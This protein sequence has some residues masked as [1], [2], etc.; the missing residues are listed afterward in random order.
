[1]FEVRTLT[2]G[3]QSAPSVLAW[4]EELIGGAQRTLDFAHYDLNLGPENASLVRDGDP[5][6]VRA[7]RRGSLP[8]QH[9]PPEPD[10]GSAASGARRRADR[11]VRRSRRAIA[12]V[13]D[14]MHHKYVVR[15]GETVW[16]GSMNWTD[17]SFTRQENVVAIVRS[18]RSQRGSRRTSPSCGRP[19]PSS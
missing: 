18:R 10:P 14:L 4:I 7:R 9:R 6:G 19:A 3:G 17:D 1:M 15:D 12:G 13:P 11:V 5:G 2:D 16:T 8:L